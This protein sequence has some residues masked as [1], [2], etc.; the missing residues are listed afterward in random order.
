MS[1]SCNYS[2]YSNN[3]ENGG[4]YDLHGGR[5][6]MLMLQELRSNIGKKKPILKRQ[7]GSRMALYRVY[8]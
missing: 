2:S 1:R 8:G 4:Y 7:L 6:E 5:L 3:D